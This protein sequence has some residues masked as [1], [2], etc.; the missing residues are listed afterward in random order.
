MLKD[1]FNNKININ[2]SKIIDSL[3]KFESNF[4][5]YKKNTQEIFKLSKNYDNFLPFQL[6]SALISIFIDNL[7]GFNNAKKYIIK[8][9][10]L[11]DKKQATDRDIN[12]YNFLNNL[13]QKNFFQALTYLDILI[14]NNHDDLFFAKIGQ[15]FYFSIG[16]NK[17]MINLANLVIKNNKKNPYALSMLSFALEEYNQI[18]KAKEV[19]LK[20]LSI[21]QSDPWSHHTLAHIFEVENKPE[22][23]ID[24]L[25]S[26]SHYW[27]D[28]NSFIYTHNWWHIALFYLKINDLNNALKIFNKHLWDSPNSDKSYSQDQAGAVSLLIRLKLKNNNIER[29]WKKVSSEIIKRKNFFSDPFIATHYAYV[30]GSVDNLKLKTKFQENIE[31]LENSKNEYDKKIW[32]KAGVPLCKAM[33]NHAEKNYKSSYRYF[34]ESIKHWSLIG[35][36]HTQRDLFKILFDEAK[37][38]NN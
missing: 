4:L 2:D 26:L 9:K 21:N 17:K 38:K 11:I 20:G 29:H 28:C 31:L 16:D 37:K 10:K 23:G 14:N 34:N 22:R 15:I 5:G 8:A 12:Y 30:I 33:I 13:L 36:S 25:K 27:N 24:T 19:A 35:G 1:Q 32:K 3:N 6:H 7:E 18:D